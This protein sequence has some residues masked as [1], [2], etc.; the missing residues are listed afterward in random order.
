[1]KKSIFLFALTLLSS[2]SFSQDYNYEF[3]TNGFAVIQ[4]K[5]LE[6]STRMDTLRLE[7]RV[8]K[9]YDKLKVVSN[10]DFS[11]VR[12][13]GKVTFAGIKSNGDL[14]YNHFISNEKQFWIFVNPSD[15]IIYFKDIQ[16]KPIAYFGSR[17][18]G[19]PIDDKF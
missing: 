6:D 11:N 13:D 15:G 14:V 1:M 7:A 10:K 19:I 12:F 8:I 4:V 5:L 3:T 9:E 17:W 16:S 18:M 2:L